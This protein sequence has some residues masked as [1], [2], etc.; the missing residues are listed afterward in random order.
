MSN[1]MRPR[2]FLSWE[3]ALF[4]ALLGAWALTLLLIERDNA[5]ERKVLVEELR[6]EAA[7]ESHDQAQLIERA[8]A[9]VYQGLRTL[10]RLPSIRNIGPDA[11]NLSFDARTSAQE[12]FNTLASHVAVP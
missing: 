2:H 11:S 8:F 9:Q 1:T 12:I 4:I 7:L 6:R 10:A 5:S 3:A